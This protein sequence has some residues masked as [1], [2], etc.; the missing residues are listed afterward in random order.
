[1][2]DVSRL[3]GLALNDSGFAFDPATGHT[4]NLNASGL[5]VVRALAGGGTPGDAAAALAATF[6]AEPEADLGRD[7]EEFVRQLREHGLVR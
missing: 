3:A 7:V 6:D 2:L 1:M 4:Y 5:A